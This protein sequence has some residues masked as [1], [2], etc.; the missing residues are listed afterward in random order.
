MKTSVS[1]LGIVTVGFA[2]L[3]SVRAEAK[4]VEW[5]GDD[6][7][8]QFVWSDDRYWDPGLPTDGDAG[9]NTLPL[10]YRAALDVGPVWYASVT[11]TLTTV[12]RTVIRSSPSRSARGICK[13]G[14]GST[15]TYERQAVTGAY[16]WYYVLSEE[17]N[18][19]I[20]A[21]DCSFN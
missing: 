5:K 13:I 14:S 17:G 3:W 11:G 12:S 4:T 9:K 16:T 19:W 10:L 18:G 1:L 20:L 21:N 15:L 2:G 7:T 6:S 8:T